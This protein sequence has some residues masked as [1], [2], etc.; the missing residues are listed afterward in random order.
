MKQILKK[1]LLNLITE[2]NMEMD[3]LAYKAKG[4]QD[5]GGRIRIRSHFQ[6]R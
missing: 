4:T 5:S 3:E 6:R 2:S 1:D